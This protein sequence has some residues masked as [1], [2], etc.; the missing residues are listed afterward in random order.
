[1]MEVVF[2]V[3]LHDIALRKRIDWERKDLVN[4]T[5]APRGMS[6]ATSW[7]RTIGAVV[8]TRYSHK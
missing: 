4:V 7:S 2:F 3:L 8:S 5:G 6:E 1:M